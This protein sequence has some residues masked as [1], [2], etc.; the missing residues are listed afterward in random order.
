[1]LK[2]FG[3]VVLAAV[4][5]IGLCAGI[6]V[7]KDMKISGKVT[8]VVEASDRNGNP[9]T[10]IILAEKRTLQGVEYD[11][12]VPAMAFGEVKSQVAQVKAGDTITF[13]GSVRYFNGGKSYTILQLLQ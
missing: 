6:A 1:M 11:A 9:Y 4:L 7:A 2:R 10:R 13:I 8:D 3:V 5:A 12:G